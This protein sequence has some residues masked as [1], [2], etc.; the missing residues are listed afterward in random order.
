MSAMMVDGRPPPAEMHAPC[1]SFGGPKGRRIPTLAREC[2][3]RRLREGW[4][5]LG[6]VAPPVR[7]GR[8][9]RSWK[10]ARL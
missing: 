9:M 1:M 10:E 3:R 2:E 6:C 4:K 8:I 5:C 7:S